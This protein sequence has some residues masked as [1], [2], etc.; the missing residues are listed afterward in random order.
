ML[1][2]YILK[3]EYRLVLSIWWV[4]DYE[5]DNITGLLKYVWLMIAGATLP[6]PTQPPSLFLAMP[7]DARIHS[8]SRWCKRKITEIVA[9]AS[10]Q[11]HGANSTY[12]QLV[13][14]LALAKQREGN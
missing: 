1:L 8:N 2:S 14:R 7:A 11:V 13:S 9:D 10:I 4:N 6:P 3:S 12:T 5:N